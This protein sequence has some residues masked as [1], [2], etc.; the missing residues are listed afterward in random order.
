MSSNKGEALALFTFLAFGLFGLIFGVGIYTN[1]NDLLSLIKNEDNP[2]AWNMSN[3][4]ANNGS[5]IFLFSLDNNAFVKSDINHTIN[6]PIDK[7]SG[8]SNDY[9]ES[10][11]PINPPIYDTPY[12]GKYSKSNLYRLNRSSVNSAANITQFELIPLGSEAG[13]SFSNNPSVE[14]IGS[15]A[16][17]KISNQNDSIM[18]Y[19]LINNSDGYYV[20]GIKPI[21]N[22]AITNIFKDAYISNYFEA[23]KPDFSLNM[24]EFVFQMKSMFGRNFSLFLLIPGGLLIVICISRLLLGG[25]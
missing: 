9:N 17:K 15:K 25:R 8:T 16:D 6:Y 4:S 11:H 1:N 5:A 7:E 21:N 22:L 3:Q 2:T 12:A 10:K 18:F 13:F 23:N 20:L 19:R 24:G 14:T